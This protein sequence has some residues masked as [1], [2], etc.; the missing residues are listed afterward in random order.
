MGIGV[1]S[2]TGLQMISLQNNQDA[3]LRS[4]AQQMAYD[5]M[6]RIRVNPGAGVAGSDYDGI[7][8]AD[9]PAA[10]QDCIAGN[11]SAA[12]MV[13][14][15]IALWKCSL[16]GLNEEDVCVGLRDD[17]LLPPLANQPGLP[18]GLGQIDVDG[19]GIITVTVQW[20]GFNNVQQTITLDSQG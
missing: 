11:C 14:F 19:A 9:V 17:G 3:L 15:D 13:G 1:L 8:L 2:V 16:G 20:S 5:I 12:Q 18:D 6:D 10:P 4:E 7:A